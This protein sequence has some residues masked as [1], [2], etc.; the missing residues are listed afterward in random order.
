MTNS[1]HS[2]ENDIALTILMSIPTP[3]TSITF[4]LTP[5]GG[6]SDEQLFK[7]CASNKGVR[8]ERTSKGELIV[9]S[10]TGGITGSRSLQL[11][12]GLGNWN[13][14]TKLGI[15][16]DSSTG[17]SLPNGAVRSP[18]A[19]WI[20]KERWAALTP[21]Q[22]RTFVPLCPDFVVELLSESDAI[23]IATAKM[24][25]W[26]TNGCRLAWLIDADGKKA[27]VFR[28]ESDVEIVSFDRTLDGGDVLPGFTFD[29]MT[30]TSL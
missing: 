17:F 29:L 27:Y 6:L 20:A 15:V 1:L 9:M 18:D 24:E 25:E 12:R 13:E 16:F 4:D 2:Q 22:Q 7:L 14:R 11:A 10:P 28:P 23:R 5:I 3:Y 8:F 21:E 19:S 26:I 30:L